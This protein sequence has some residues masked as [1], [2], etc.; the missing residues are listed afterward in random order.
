MHNENDFGP[1]GN[2]GFLVPG[3]QIYIPISP[4]CCFAYYCAS[5]VLEMQKGLFL[6][7]R[8]L[9]KAKATRVLT[10]Y[11]NNVEFNSQIDELEDK[12]HKLQVMY[13]SIDIGESVQMDSENVMFVNSLSVGSAERQV[14]ARQASDLTLAKGIVRDSP[15]HAAPRRMKLQ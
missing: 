11:F 14:Y 1:Y 9:Q 15:D 4:E 5:N 13:K 10:G 7:E 6:T 12:L 2:L 8:A 3:V